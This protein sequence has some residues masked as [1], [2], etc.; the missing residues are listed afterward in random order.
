MALKD[1]PKKKKIFILTGVLLVLVII[2]E[3]GFISAGTKYLLRGRTEVYHIRPEARGEKIQP[4]FLQIPSLG[5][6]VPLVY[7]TEKN[8][9]AYQKALEDGAAHFP[10][11]AEPGQFG[12]AYIFGHSSDYLWSPGKYKTVF[13]TLPKIRLGD[14]IAVSDRG[15]NKFVYKVIESKKVAADDLSVLDQGDG[16]KKLLTIQTSY[17]IGTALARWVVIAEIK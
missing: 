15:G 14:E 10:D 13:A 12:N 7:V 11:T 16:T 6:K 17:P 4:D 2:L 8:E 1:L 9:T 3:F 5:I